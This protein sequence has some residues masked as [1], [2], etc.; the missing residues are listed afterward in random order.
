MNLVQAEQ[1][2][3]DRLE[4]LRTA[5]LLVRSLPNKSSEQGKVVGNGVLTLS[6]TSDEPSQPQS[7]LSGSFQDATVN[8]VIDGRITNLREASGILVVRQAIYDLTI[9]FRPKN[10]GPLYARRFEFVERTELYWRFEYRLACTT[11]LQGAVQPTPG[12]I[13]V[14]LREVFF[15]APIISDQWSVNVG[16]GDLPPPSVI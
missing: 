6:W 14:K 12:D 15:D 13:G 5:G 7:S 8:W 10:C 4:P 16:E 3:L 9:G 11:V 1:D 2:I